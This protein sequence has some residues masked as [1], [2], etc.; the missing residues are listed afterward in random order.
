M[1]V[2]GERHRLEAYE[3]FWRTSR[4]VE[5]V[6]WR[7]ATRLSAW[8]LPGHQK[9]LLPL[10]SSVPS[11][12]TLASCDLWPGGPIPEPRL[13]DYRGLT[14]VPPTAR[15]GVTCRRWRPAASRTDMPRRRPRFF[16]ADLTRWV[17]SLIFF[18]PL[19][20]WRFLPGLGSRQAVIGA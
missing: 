16:V 2:A 11:L 17:G 19:W 9:V 8:H 13:A 20:R 5:K 1:V 15:A 3:L 18:G 10:T 6:L 7:P 4:P 12:L 14:G